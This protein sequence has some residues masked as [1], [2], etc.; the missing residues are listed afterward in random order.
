METAPLSA[1]LLA[2]TPE[3]PGI[4]PQP[5]CSCDTWLVWRQGYATP[6]L[7]SFRELLAA[8]RLGA[9]KANDFHSQ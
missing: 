8:G 2:L 3:Y 4:N 7:S 5:L 9:Q 1:S 6:T